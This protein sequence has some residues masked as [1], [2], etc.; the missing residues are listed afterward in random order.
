MSE[1]E[2]NVDFSINKPNLKIYAI[3]V[4][5]RHT[6]Y[7]FYYIRLLFHRRVS[8]IHLLKNKN[9]DIS[10]AK[11]TGILEKILCLK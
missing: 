2:F 6:L 7:I 4:V 8:L 3:C 5:C 9:R 1:G 11:L 10:R